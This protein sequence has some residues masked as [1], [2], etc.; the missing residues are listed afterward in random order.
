MSTILEEPPGFSGSCI[1]LVSGFGHFLG[2]II[3]ALGNLVSDSGTHPDFLLGDSRNLLESYSDWEYLSEENSRHDLEK[4]EREESMDHDGCG[5]SVVFPRLRGADRSSRPCS[6]R[7]PR[8]VRKDIQRL[9]AQD[10]HFE[11]SKRK[12]IRGDFWEGD[13]D[14]N[15]LLFRVRQFTGSPRPLHLIAFPVESLP[16]LPFTELPPPFSLKNPFFHW[17]VLRRIPFPKI[18]SKQRSADIRNSFEACGFLTQIVRSW[19]LRWKLGKQPRFCKKSLSLVNP[20]RPW[21]EN[22][23]KLARINLPQNWA[24]QKGYAT[25]KWHFL[26][27]SLFLVTSKSFFLFSFLSFWS[28]L[29]TIFCC[30]AYRFAFAYLFCGLVMHDFQYKTIRWR[31]PFATCRGGPFSPPSSVQAEQ[32][33]LESQQ[34]PDSCCNARHDHI[35][36]CCKPLPSTTWNLEVIYEPLPLRPRI[37]VKDRSS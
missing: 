8:H 10:F 25:T 18:G 7:W 27:R 36:R 28:L 14:S 4:R 12:Q 9:P 30:F 23:L 6:S 31:L 24:R 3:M 35:M 20:Q 34:C 13:E 21:K 37:L 17:K 5:T 15:F 22:T 26:S 19:F 1:Q 2:Q 33:V 16:N 29:V 11:L 32:A